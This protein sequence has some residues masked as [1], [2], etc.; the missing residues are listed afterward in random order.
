ML[1][2]QDSQVDKAKE[3]SKQDNQWGWSFRSIANTALIIVCT[4]FSNTYGTFTKTN[5]LGH[6]TSVGFIMEIITN[7]L[8]SAIKLEIKNETRKKPRPSTWKFKNLTLNNTW[9]KGELQREITEFLKNNDNGNTIYIR[10]YR[11]FIRS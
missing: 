6:K 11:H 1:S 9:V 3:R 10:T 5:I 4:F 7:T 8:I 2:I